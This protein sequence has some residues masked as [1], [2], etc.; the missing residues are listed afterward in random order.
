[1]TTQHGT[2]D[3]TSGYTLLN[4]NLGIY[5]LGRFNRGWKVLDALHPADTKR[6]TR[7]SGL[8]KDWPR[9]KILSFPQDEIALVTPTLGRCQHIGNN[10]KVSSASSTTFI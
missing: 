4:E 2:L 9:E 10:G 6:G 7:A 5:F 8:H 3:F 1:M